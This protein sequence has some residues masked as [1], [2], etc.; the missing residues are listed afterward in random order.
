[1]TIKLG[2]LSRW[3]PFGASALVLAGREYGERRIRLNLNC[4]YETALY[5]VFD[6]V[7]DQQLVAVAP[8]GVTTVEF[9][10]EGNIGL[11]V[12]AKDGAQVWY[13]TADDEPTYVE[14]VDPVIFTKIANRRHRN[15]ELEEM[16]YR[17]QANVERRLA[18]QAS[19]F[20]AALER[21]R[22]EEENGRPAEIVKSNAPGANTG[23]VGGEVP[24]PEPVAPQPGE[25]P[26][27]ADGGGQPGDGSG[28]AGIGVA[29]AGGS[30]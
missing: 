7:E 17:M 27:S 6:G 1:M 29:P 30:Q 18:A 20:E 11:I 26:G 24:Q 5:R 2:S 3:K 28:T 9:T 4:E 25:A 8:A 15:P 21:R 19:E 13:Q 10:A 16:M 22:Q 23:P 12:V 14:V